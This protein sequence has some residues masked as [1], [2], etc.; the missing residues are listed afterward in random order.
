MAAFDL[1]GRTSHR[2]G[3]RLQLTVELESALIIGETDLGSSP[4]FPQKDVLQLG[5]ALRAGLSAGSLGGVL[6]VLFASGDS[7]YDDGD[8]NNFK[9]DPNFEMGLLLYRQVL[10]GQ[11][12][13]APFTASDPELVGRPNE[14]LERFPTRGSATNTVALFPRAWWRPLAGLEVHGGPLVAFTPVSNADPLNSRVA[15]GVPRTALDGD[16]GGYLGTELDVGVRYQ[17]L[18]GGTLLMA[19]L[20]GGVLF[21]GSAL[22]AADGSTLD[23]IY[24]GRFLLAYQL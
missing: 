8:Q 2:L 20:E 15:G 10:A 6:D 18:L 9:P 14:D 12:G 13:R 19:G 17:A 7:N 4:E 24:G 21:P 5:V 3:K 11:T 1:Y 23:P 22:A 16:P